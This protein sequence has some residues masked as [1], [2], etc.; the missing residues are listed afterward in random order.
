MRLLIIEDDSRTARYLMR[1]LTES[2]HVG[3][4]LTV[5]DPWAAA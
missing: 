1:G 3:C 2:G 4:G 5:I